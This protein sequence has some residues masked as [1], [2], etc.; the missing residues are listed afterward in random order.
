MGAKLFL[1]FV[2]EFKSDLFLIFNEHGELQRRNSISFQLVLI[3]QLLPSLEDLTIFQR[4]WALLNVHA[5]FILLFLW[6]LGPLTTWI[7]FSSFGK[8]EL[9]V[10]VSFVQLIKK[11]PSGPLKN[12]FILSFATFTQSKRTSLKYSPRRLV[13][14]KL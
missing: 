1:H 12:R 7:K 8:E 5:N 11:F 9:W 13:L 6:V 4:H 14:Q 3:P 2:L 10:H